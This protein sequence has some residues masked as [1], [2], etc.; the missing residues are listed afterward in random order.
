MSHGAV[1]VDIHVPD[2]VDLGEAAVEGHQRSIDVVVRKA[3]DG[4]QYVTLHFWSVEDQSVATILS[5]NGLWLDRLM[6][7]L[8]LKPESAKALMGLLA[9][10]LGYAVLAN[11]STERAERAE[12]EAAEAAA[13]DAEDQS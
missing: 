4:K 2:F 3:E 7:T 11:I 13:A 9:D 8:Y 5:P 1:N 6:A 12:R 10:R